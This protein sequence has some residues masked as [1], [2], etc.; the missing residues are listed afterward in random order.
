MML[1]I[2]LNLA[3][4]LELLLIISIINIMIIALRGKIGLVMRE[5]MMH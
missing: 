4:I 1:L 2:I 5:A 3:Q